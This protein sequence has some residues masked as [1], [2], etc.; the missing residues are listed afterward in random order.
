MLQITTLPGNQLGLLVTPS[1]PVPTYIEPAAK[2]QL[3]A[4]YY[5]HDAIICEVGVDV[6][7]TLNDE[8]LTASIEI[9]ALKAF[10]IKTGMNDYCFDSADYCGCHVQDSGSFEVDTYISENLNE[11]VRGYLEA[12]KA[13]QFNV[14]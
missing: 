11:A 12:I 2:K 10:V 14:N 8:W 9:Q 4:V 3:S 6:E 7:Y 5:V 1:A 13:G